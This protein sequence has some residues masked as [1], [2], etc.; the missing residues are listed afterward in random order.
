MKK[1]GY[2]FLASL[3]LNKLQDMEDFND[4]T[5]NSF[6]IPVIQEEVK[7]EKKVVEKGKVK[8]YK[9]VKEETESL[10]LPEINETSIQ[11]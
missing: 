9:T 3:L 1:N 6:S 10:S 11:I 7:L 4:Q 2:D 5:D 8:I